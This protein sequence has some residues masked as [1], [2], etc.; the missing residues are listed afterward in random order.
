MCLIK[1]PGKNFNVL[2]VYKLIV[3]VCKT[4]IHSKHL[5]LLL[6]LKPKVT[7]AICYFHWGITLY[8]EIYHHTYVIVAHLSEILHR[9][10]I[11]TT[12]EMQVHTVLT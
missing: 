3:L 5:K 6:N 7:C 11:C 8:R 10:L 2:N 9:N 12:L 1:N 4:V